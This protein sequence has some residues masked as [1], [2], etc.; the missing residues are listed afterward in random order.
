M[1]IHQTA[2]KLRGMKLPAMAAE[3]LRQSESR[4][5]DALDFDERVGMMADAEWRMRENNR[6]LR[7]TKTANLRFSD[8]SFADIDYRPSRKLDKSSVAR[9]SDFGWVKDAR[10]LIITGAAGCGKTWLACAFGVEACRMGLRVS[11]FRVNRL[12]NKMA[13]SDDAGTLDKLLNKLKKT[14]I[15]IL[16]DWGMASLNPIEGRFLLELFEDRYNESSTIF[17]AQVPVAK[18]H[19]LFEDGTVADAIL[20]R[21][22][23]NSHRFELRGQSLRAKLGGGDIPPAGDGD[24]A[25]VVPS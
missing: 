2:E 19:E 24:G 15:L 13:A 1:M 5:C 4:V 16:D 23:H 3:Y 25:A 17:S 14:D 9:L 11:F 22:V 20:D 7:L 12:L 8:A 21:I 18:W 10:N 6:I